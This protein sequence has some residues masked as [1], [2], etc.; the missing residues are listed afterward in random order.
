MG[1]GRISALLH[2]R[3]GYFRTGLSAGVRE[4]VGVGVGNI[5]HTEPPVQCSAV[6]YAGHWAG[7][8]QALD[9]RQCATT[10]ESTPAIADTADTAA[11]E[12]CRARHITTYSTTQLSTTYTP[13]PSSAEFPHPSP[14]ATISS[15]LSPVSVRLL[16]FLFFFVWG[17]ASGVCWLLTLRCLADV[18]RGRGA[19]GWD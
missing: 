2:G 8:G 7:T 6:R 10:Y 18:R 3:D 5:S 4:G 19:P 15:Y 11:W 9:N 1:R 12:L 14:F 13:N 16:T 17:G